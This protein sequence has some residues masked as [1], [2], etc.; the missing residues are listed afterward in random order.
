MRR[1]FTNKRR[2]RFYGKRIGDLVSVPSPTGENFRARKIVEVVLLGIADNNSLYTAWEHGPHR[3]V[4]EWCELVIPVEKRKCP[5]C[6][7]RIMPYQKFVEKDS[8]FRHLKCS[9]P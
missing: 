5:V 4:A 7:T 2:D 6:N 3:E 1:K 9:K 8:T